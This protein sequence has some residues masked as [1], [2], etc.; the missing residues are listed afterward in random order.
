MQG[1]MNALEM[2]WIEGLMGGKGKNGW[3]GMDGY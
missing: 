1:I 2:C 3:N